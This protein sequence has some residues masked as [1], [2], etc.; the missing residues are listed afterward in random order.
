M[1][2]F[3]I[4]IVYSGEKYA[5]FRRGTS[6]AT[7]YSLAFN[8]GATI[9]VAASSSGTI[10][11]FSMVDS[12]SSSSSTSSTSS[13]GAVSGGGDGG[14]TA[15][16]PPVLEAK[17][18]TSSP[19]PPSSSSAPA[20][21]TGSYSSSMVS[22]AAGS[23]ASMGGSLLS[24]TGSSVYSVFSSASSVFKRYVPYVEPSR[25]ISIIKMKTPETPCILAFSPI[26]KVTRT[27]SLLLVTA[28]GLFFEV[29]H[30]TLQDIM[31]F[32]FDCVFCNHNTPLHSIW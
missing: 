24:S 10:H 18:P 21:S 19:P 30:Y 16:I 1:H 11:I 27:Q 4:K 15:T 29:T 28:D 14:S 32:V 17:L 7:I 13:S 3:I 6:N 31:S 20:T 8:E 12:T 23:I 9:I 2:L 22:A 25:A 5:S 26:D